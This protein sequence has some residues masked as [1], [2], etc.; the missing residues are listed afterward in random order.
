M[1]SWLAPLK[2]ASPASA[3]VLGVLC[4]KL[5]ATEPEELSAMDGDDFLGV[6]EV[7]PKL[8]RNCFKVMFSEISTVKARDNKTA[9]QVPPSLPAAES[10]TTRSAE[11][12]VIS[13]PSYETGG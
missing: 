9:T 2:L 13:F 3:A 10:T 1:E 6:L 5:G 12:P 8:K 4:T 7:V 11:I